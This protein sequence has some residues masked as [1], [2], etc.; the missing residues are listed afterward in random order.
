MKMFPPSSFCLRAVLFFGLAVGSAAGLEPEFEW[1][2]SAG[3]ALHDKTRGIATDGQ[4]NVFLTG[5]FT[6]TATFGEH[7]LTSVGGMDFFIAKVDPAGKFLW[8]RSGGGDKIDRGYAIATD[9]KGNSYVTGHFE[10]SEA[11]FGTKKIVNK[12]NYDLFVAKYDPNGNLLW[13]KA[14]GGAGSDNGHGIA[15]DEMGHVFVTGSVVGGFTLDETPL[16]GA[17]GSHVF[18]LM[19][20]PDDKIGWCRVAEGDGSSSG[21]SISVDQRGNCFVGGSAGGGG[22][23][24]GVA[25]TNVK[26]RDVLVTCFNSSGRNVWLHQGYGSGGAMIHGI[27]ADGA[28][29]VWAAG[30][31]KGELKLQ[32]RAVQSAGKDDILLMNFNPKGELKWTKTGGGDGIDY[33]LG[34]A[35]D[36]AGN[37]VLSGSFQGKMTFGDAEKTSTGGTDIYLA[38]FDESGKQ[39]WFLQPEGKATEHA[40]TL[41]LDP[42]G[43]LFISGACSGPTTFGKHSVGNLG[44]NDVFLAKVRFK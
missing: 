36:S 30:M 5:E 33:G 1:V 18:C 37:S 17:G 26:G 2:I 32:E 7:T 21:Q 19:L 29:N 23:F 8:V 3:G 27:K 28:G 13:I 11:F 6:G 24:G 31:F 9:K 4:G 12:G 39:T 35:A 22:S 44:S 34:V 38:G 41:A 15:V 25:L 20:D 16:G 42:S 10:S 14:G 40:Y 43:S